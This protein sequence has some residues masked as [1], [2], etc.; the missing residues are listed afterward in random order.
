MKIFTAGFLTETNTFAPF[1]AGRATFEDMMFY[2]RGEHVNPPIE[3]DISYTFIKRAQ[4]EGWEVAAGLRAFAQPAGR[5]VKAAYEELLGEILDDLRDAM[6][7][8][9]V[10]LSLHGA[11]V[12][13]HE[14]DGEG[15]TIERIR[16]LVGPDVPIGVHCDPHCHLTDKMVNNA[17]VIKTW[18]EYPH[19]DIVERAGEVFDLIK[20]QLEGAPRPIPVVHD[21]RMI[22]MFHTTKE[23]MRSFVD[24]IIA[25]EGKDGIPVISIAH[26]FPWGDVPEM[27][28][29]VLVYAEDESAVPAAQALAKSL[30]EEIWEMKEKVGPTYL[31]MDEA[32]DKAYSAPKGPVVI[33]DGPDNPGGGSPSDS[34][35]FMERLIERGET[36][37]TIG[38]V[39]DP[40]AARIA[41]EAGEGA[42]LSLRVGGKVCALSG[43]PIDVKAKVHKIKPD[44]YVYFGALPM[45]VGDAVALDLGQNRFVLLVTCRNQAFDPALFEDAGIT[46][47]DK[48]AVIVKSSQ[49]FYALF[50]K[51][52]ADV[53]YASPPG[54]TASNFKAL[55]YENADTTKWGMVD[56]RP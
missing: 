6:P 51:V 36:D 25:L 47:A 16:Q 26:G 29:K 27:G 37:W 40:V 50:S 12:A 18:K 48:K 55:P 34:T 28:T 1:P 45:S 14:D 54:V 4:E 42:E 15:D 10:F 17:D 41:I 20:A 5:V 9:A 21:C 13:E 30:G 2:R 53:L 23:P 38:Y 43:N 11:M 52:A 56:Y 3:P 32:L 35:Y 22:T 33:S 44:A 39:Y 19:T 31:T 49:H 24:K 8:D 46:L 7:V